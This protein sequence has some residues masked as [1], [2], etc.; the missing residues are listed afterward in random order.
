[1]QPWQ[2]LDWHQSKDQHGLELIFDLFGGAHN[3]S[4]ALGTFGV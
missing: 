4:Y 3:N 2:A 1:M